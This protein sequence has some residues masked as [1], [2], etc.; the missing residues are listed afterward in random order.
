MRV[1]VLVVPRME[2][3]VIAARQQVRPA[4]AGFAFPVIRSSEN[5]WGAACRRDQVKAGASLWSEDD[6]A[7][8]PP[9][10]TTTEGSAAEDYRRPA[11]N[12]NLFQGTVR[13]KPQ[14]LTV[15]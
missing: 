5:P 13:K 9:T 15:G 4:V 10:S 8:L 14:P 1:S 7:I 11:C 12:W 6:D 3:N 2:H